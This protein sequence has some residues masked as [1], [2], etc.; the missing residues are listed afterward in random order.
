MSNE[1][2]RPMYFSQI[3]VDPNHCDVV[4]L[5]GVGPTL[6]AHGGDGYLAQQ[7][8]VVAWERVQSSD[9]WPALAGLGYFTEYVPRLD[10]TRTVRLLAL[11]P[12]LALGG[13]ALVRSSPPARA[14]VVSAVCGWLVVIG[15][16][17]PLSPAL[18]RPT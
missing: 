4:Y 11:V 5:G 12:L 16:H 8:A 18:E 14:L 2:Q 15:F 6:N 9:W 10:P 17:G 3:R 7:R 13:A 1:N